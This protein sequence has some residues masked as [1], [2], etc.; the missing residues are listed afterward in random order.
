MLSYKNGKKCSKVICQVIW[1]IFERELLNLLY[2]SESWSWDFKIVFFLFVFQFHCIFLI[3]GVG[4]ISRVSV[5]LQKTNNLSFDVPLLWDASFVT[6]RLCW[7]PFLREGIF[8]KWSSLFV[9]VSM[10]VIN[11]GGFSHFDQASLL[12]I[13]G[14]VTWPSNVL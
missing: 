7:V 5:V 1:V 11:V 8:D 3:V 9:T 4:F 12:D 14:Y 6:C 10:G 13:L 2:D